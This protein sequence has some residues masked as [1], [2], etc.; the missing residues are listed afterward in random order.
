MRAERYCFDYSV[1]KVM[2]DEAEKIISMILNVAVNE[3]TRTSRGAQV[4]AAVKA[5]VTDLAC[6]C[7]IYRLGTHVNNPSIENYV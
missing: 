2:F 4:V 7:G 1:N 3:G 6:R 5:E